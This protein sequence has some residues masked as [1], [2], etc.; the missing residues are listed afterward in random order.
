MDFTGLD[1]PLHRFPVDRPLTEEEKAL[2]FRQGSKR[3]AESK[4]FLSAI[5]MNSTYLEVVD[6]W[7]P[8]K[9]FATSAGG[10]GTYCAFIWFGYH[11]IYGFCQLGF[12]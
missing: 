5:K 6:R 4:C 11:A 7:Y 3:N 12:S 2:R 8:I 9:G 10:G 1:N